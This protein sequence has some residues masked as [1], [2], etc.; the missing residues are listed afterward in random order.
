M[1]VQL[2]F[3]T[4]VSKF[5]LGRDL[6]ETELNFLMNLPVRPNAGNVTGLDTYLF[7]NTVLSN[8]YKFVNDK[9]QFCFENIYKPAKNVNLRITQSWINYTKKDQFHHKHT[10]ANSF[11]SG[12]FYVN[13][14]K[15]T[16]RIHF[17]NEE[18]KA[19]DILARELTILN[20]RSWW[21]PVETGDLIL[22]PSSLWHSV[23]VVNTDTTR[24]SLAFNTFPVG[25]VGND[26]ELTGLHL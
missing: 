9:V 23:E 14:N 12:V 6:T 10:H 2:L 25:Y 24:A 16:D 5:K 4:F 8:L 18:H 26:I 17:H 15:D 13:A 19:F 20:S 3:P 11:I 7:E 22:F 21:Y 1:S